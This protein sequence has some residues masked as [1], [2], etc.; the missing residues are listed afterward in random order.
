MTQY[1]P[2]P[3]SRQRPASRRAIAGIVALCLAIGVPLS[4]ASDSDAGIKLFAVEIRVGPGWDADKAPAEQRNFS[5]HS[6]HLKALR[7]AGRIVMGARYSEVGLLVVSAESEAAVRTLMDADP[8]MA[9]GTFR[10]DVH[11]MNVFYPWLEAAGEGTS[12]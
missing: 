6:R 11:T 12:R 2:I 3:S 5:A 7:D 1:E 8:S 10:Y 4:N 9:A